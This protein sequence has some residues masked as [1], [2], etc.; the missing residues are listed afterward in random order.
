LRYEDDPYRP[1][2]KKKI[3]EETEAEKLAE[4]GGPAAEEAENL[5]PI[6]PNTVQ[7]APAKKENEF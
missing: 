7:Q 2:Y 1:Y 6:E 3:E 5:T 4:E